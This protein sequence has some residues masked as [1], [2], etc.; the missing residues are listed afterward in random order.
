MDGTSWRG[1]PGCGPAFFRTSSRRG[2]RRP[3]LC[4]HGRRPRR[5]LGNISRSPE[6]GFVSAHRFL[7]L[8]VLAAF[9]LLL[10]TFLGC[11]RSNLND[12]ALPDGGEPDASGDS[13]TDSPI[14]SPVDVPDS[15]PPI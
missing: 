15:P 2:H 8:S 7:Q 3:D 5:P 10:A 11:S 6:E 1:G 9:G 13:P 12:Y 14:D 4:T